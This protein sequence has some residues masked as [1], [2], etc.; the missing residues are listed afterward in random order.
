[1]KT[2]TVFAHNEFGVLF[3]CT[4]EAINTSQLFAI[5]RIE[6]PEAEIDDYYY[7]DIY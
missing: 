5:F 3:A 4:I 2:Y 7:D 1:M 6:Y